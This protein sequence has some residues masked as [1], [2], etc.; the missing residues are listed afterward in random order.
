[1]PILNAQ[2]GL[3]GSFVAKGIRKWFGLWMAKLSNM[4]PTD[5]CQDDNNMVHKDVHYKKYTA[6]RHDHGKARACMA[7]HARM[8]GDAK[9]S[10]T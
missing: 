10:G 8:Q 7:R 9:W 6:P 3:E 1:M 2:L 4:T 5:G